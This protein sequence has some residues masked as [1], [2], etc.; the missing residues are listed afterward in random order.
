MCPHAQTLLDVLP[1]AV[2]ALRGE[3]R[4]HSDYLMTS[5]C[6]LVGQDTKKR[7]PTRITDA[8]G[9][10]AIPHEARHLQVLDTDAAILPCVLVRRLEVEVAALARDL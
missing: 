9:E 1:T 8:L 3:A 7:A 2:A 5:S 6:S 4:G 10:M